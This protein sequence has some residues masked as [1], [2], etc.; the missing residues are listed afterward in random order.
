MEVTFAGL[1]PWVYLAAPLV[2]GA[3]Y[4]VFGLTGFGA[5]MITVPLLAHFLPISYLV[6]VMVLLDLASSAL[7]GRR[8]REDVS[9]VELK[10]LTPLMLAGFVAGVTLLIGV[11]D[12]YLR[13]ALGLFAVTVGVY[14]IFNPTLTRTISAWWAVPAGII[15]GAIATVF[16]AGGP[17]YA[18]YLSGRLS[19]KGE[20]RATVAALI[21]ISAFSRALIYAVSGLLLHLAIFVGVALLAPFAWIGITLGQRIHVGLTQAQMR[22]VVGVLLVASGLTLLARAL[23]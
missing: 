14:G 17:I 4:V 23:L 9:R 15:G 13:V 22:R 18:T 5:T 7:L 21:L 12:Q 11:Q 6:P 10:R 2:V 8:T 19:D 3:A 16:G 1:S 20:L